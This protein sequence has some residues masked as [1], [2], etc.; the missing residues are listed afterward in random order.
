[1]AWKDLDHTLARELAAA[2]E[3][4]PPEKLTEEMICDALRARGYLWFDDEKSVD[5]PTVAGTL[6]LAKKPSIGLL[7]ARVQ[8]DAFVG[9]EPDPRPLDSVIEDMPITLI[10]KRA[11]AFVRRN[12]KQPLVVHGWKRIEQDP[13]PMDAVR[14]AVVNAVA[15]RDYEMTGAKI[16]IQLFVDRLVVTSPGF[17]PGGAE[18]MDEIRSGKAM[19]RARNPLIVQAFVLLKLMEERGSGIS[20]I[21]REMT[22][23]GY[24]EPE[25]NLTR[26][27]FA[28]TLW[29]G[30]KIYG[31]S[32]A[33]TAAPEE[34]AQTREPRTDWNNDP[35]LSANERVVLDFISE[36]GHSTRAQC[37]EH[38]KLSQ[39]GIGKILSGL[40]AKG[41]LNKT[42]FGKGTGYII[43]KVD[44]SPKNVGVK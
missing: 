26:D 44:Q 12:S 38:T 37:E 17:P 41:Y 5:R 6:L 29:Y 32:T 15:H 28:V 2:A 3:N 33:G 30:T 10:E 18:A 42:G 39:A 20:R 16:V 36:N 27:S 4:L 22:E 7:Q 14:E 9:V 21:R 13:M 1:L 31:H 40:V 35:N 8:M 34:P 25:F 23:N 43:A 11:S 24:E 19:S